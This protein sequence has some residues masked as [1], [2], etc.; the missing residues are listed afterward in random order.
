MRRLEDEKHNTEEYLWTILDLVE[1]ALS[2][3][4]TAITVGKDE[5]ADGKRLQAKKP[6]GKT[7]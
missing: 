2:A 5:I 3:L 1:E 6:K 7:N 4:L